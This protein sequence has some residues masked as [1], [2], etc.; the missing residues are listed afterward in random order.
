MDVVSCLYQCT[1]S[2]HNKN[3][4]LLSGNRLSLTSSKKSFRNDGSS[5]AFSISLRTDGNRQVN[6]CSSVVVCSSDVWSHSGSIPSIP[7]AIDPS[8]EL[9]W[10]ADQKSDLEEWGTC[11]FSFVYKS[12]SGDMS[13][14]FLR[15]GD[16]KGLNTNVPDLFFDGDG[17]DKACLHGVGL[18]ENAGG[19]L[20]E[21][22]FF[23]YSESCVF[24]LPWNGAAKER[25]SLEEK[26]EEI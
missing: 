22:E 2:T 25:Y 18:H 20:R 3:P 19:F 10:A 4:M 23:L 8:P 9:L 16:L 7:S 26:K 14:C 12:F 21:F 6:S 24:F 17:V 11:S 5:P 1:I 15:N 13:L